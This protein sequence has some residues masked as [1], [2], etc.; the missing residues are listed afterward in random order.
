MSRYAY[1]RVDVFT[2][3]AFGG[4]PLA[5]F[6]D[7]AAVP[8]ELYQSIA[9]EMNLSETTFV[10]PSEDPACDFKVRIFTP[11]TELPM[12]GH[13]TVG[14]AFVLTRL[15][16]FDPATNNGVL[17]LEEAV[18][19]IP[20]TVAMEG[21]QPGQITMSQPMPNFG[22]IF[23]D[24]GAIA[25]A[26]SLEADDLEADVPV[27]TVSCG[28][29]F[30]FA[31]IRTR[32]AVARAVPRLDLCKRIF[33]GTD[34]IGIFLFC[35]ETESPLAAVHS[36]MFAPWSGVPEDPAT[37]GASGPLGCY[38]LR[39]GMLGEDNEFTIVSEQGMEMGRPSFLTI[40]IGSG[41]DGIDKVQVGG[42]SVY[43][44]EGILDL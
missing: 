16:L 9:R 12:A 4:N 36:R 22:T 31:P 42:T 19:P 28:A 27:Q 8:S 17:T 13:P 7:G 39:Y 25:A 44:G 37:G 24:R 38:L 6:P 1:H 34:V 10:M 32:A 14:T 30:A 15:G 29:P 5:V 33:A 18:G 23:G 20:V 21:G 2:D 41:A 40:T 35:R 3:R 11:A 43:M 26:L